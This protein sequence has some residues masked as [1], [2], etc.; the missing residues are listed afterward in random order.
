[1]TFNRMC[2]PN[3]PNANS[4]YSVRLR[5]FPMYPTRDYSQA[6]RA[7]QI[8]NKPA[9]ATRLQLGSG[10]LFDGINFINDGVRAFV[11]AENSHSPSSLKKSNKPRCK[12]LVWC[13][14]DDQQPCVHKL[15]S[16][17]STK[18]LIRT[19]PKV[20]SNSHRCNRRTFPGN[21]SI[22]FDAYVFLSDTLNSLFQFIFSRIASFHGETP[23][24]LY[25]PL[26]QSSRF[27]P[28]FQ[29]SCSRTYTQRFQS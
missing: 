8:S 23:S 29:H 21:S 7:A 22:G 10:L 17:K 14:F 6:Y 3:A 16:G 1:M 9:E 12:F 20:C 11:L 24:K 2:I 18:H 5:T 26:T 25:E 15:I 4:E 28:N 13:L 27:A 19:A